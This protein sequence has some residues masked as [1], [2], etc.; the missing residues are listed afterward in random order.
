M[1]GSRC[2]W[3][4]SVPPSFD[5]E[6]DRRVDEHHPLLGAAEVHRRV[7]EG[8]SVRAAV[9][10]RGTWARVSL[11][12]ILD[13]WHSKAQHTQPQRVE[14][15]HLPDDVGGRGPDGLQPRGVQRVLHLQATMIPHVAY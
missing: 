5:R 8:V 9:T 14:R 1:D 13:T 10:C 3:I 4:V 15:H 7:A 12:I 2:R 6:D 11:L